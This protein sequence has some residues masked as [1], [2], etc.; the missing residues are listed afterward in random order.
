VA[1]QADDRRAKRTAAAGAGSAAAGRAPAAPRRYDPAE[2]R[3]RVIEAAYHLFATVGYK[4]TGTADIARA[5]DVSEGSI[6]YHFGSKRALLGELGRLHGAKMVAAMQA[7]DPLESLDPADVI[8]RCFRFC[9]ENTAWEAMNAGAECESTYKDKHHDPEAEP[10]FLAA[11]EVT[12]AWVEQH[13]A[14]FNAAHGVEGVDPAIAAS[15]TFTAVGDALHLA[16]RPGVSEEERAH[17]L[18]QTIR[19]IRGACMG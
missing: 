15:L 9:A 5:A 7:G 3:T 13:I 1:T 14:A 4:E 10:F 2:T 8:S 12:Q 16:F 11:R 18:A 17:I 6:F 19:F